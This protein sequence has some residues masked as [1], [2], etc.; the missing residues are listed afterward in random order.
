MISLGVAIY[1]RGLTRG[2]NIPGCEY[3]PET[4]W[5]QYVALIIH[6]SCISSP[7]VLGLLPSI[8]FLLKAFVSSFPSVC[9]TLPPIEPPVVN[10]LPMAPSLSNGPPIFCAVP[11][12]APSAK[13]SISLA[14]LLYICTIEIPIFLNYT[15]DL[16]V[17]CLPIAPFASNAD[18]PVPVVFSPAGSLLG[19]AC[20]W[21][22]L[23][24]SCEGIALH[25]ER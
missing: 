20:S 2:I 15:Y 22:A 6:H 16:L 12:I 18:V 19:I 9:C 24:A 14:R 21:I 4:I 3:V 23:S 10:C 5:R 1:L 25:V 13:I 17:N 11:P 8:Y 7:A